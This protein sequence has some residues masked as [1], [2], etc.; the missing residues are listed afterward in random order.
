MRFRKHDGIKRIMLAF[1]WLVLAARAGAVTQ[2]A[3]EAG[4][5]SGDGNSVPNCTFYVPADVARVATGPNAGDIYVAD[6]GNHVIRKISAGGTVSTVAGTFGTAGCLNGVGTSAQFNAPK[7]VAVDAGG[8]TLYVAD[9]N[10][11]TIRRLLLTGPQAGTV[12]VVAGV[13]LTT[14]STNGNTTVARFNL[15][16]DVVLDALGNTLFVADTGN[17]RIRVIYMLNAANYAVGTFAGGSAG[18]ID[19]TT[20]T[21]ARF[22]A[23]AALALEPAG[24]TLYV[25]D[26]NNQ[27]IRRIVTLG[28]HPVTTLAGLAG[29]RGAADGDSLT[30]QF[31]YP[32]GLA[33][34]PGNTSV[35]VSDG[36]NHT[37]RRIDVAAQTTATWLGTAGNT[38]SA[39]GTGTSAQFNHPCG[40]VL[41]GTAAYLYAADV[42]NDCIRRIAVATGAVETWAGG[43]GDGR[44][45]P[46]C[47]FR[48]PMRLCRD[49]AGNAY[50]AD[51]DS[52]VIRRLAS[53]GLVSTLAG[54]AGVAG[55]ADGVGDAARFKFPKGVA[56]SPD[57]QTLYVA[58][59]DNH[60]LRQVALSG[61][62]TGQVSLLAG[63]AGVT[64]TAEGSIGVGGAARFFNPQGLAVSPSG[65]YLYVADT[66]NHSIRRVDL[67]TLN[68]QT[69]FGSLNRV[70]G[71]A[72]GVGTAARFSYPTDLALDAGGN[73]LYV[74]DSGNR[75][76][77]LA[78]LTTGEV[79]TFLG[80]SAGL[81]NPQGVVT[82]DE[83]VFVADA[84]GH[85]LLI[86]DPVR[87]TCHTLAGT[88]EAGFADGGFAAAEFNM[89]L[90]LCYSQD[91]LYVADGFNRRIRRLENLFEIREVELTPV[92]NDIFL[93]GEPEQLV[94]QIAPTI[95]GRDTLQSVTVHNR[96]GTGTAPDD[97]K[98]VRCWFQ[99]GGGTFDALRAVLLGPLTVQSD[100]KTWTSGVFNQVM[101]QTDAIY[102]TL[103]VGDVPTASRTCQFG[104]PAGGLVFASAA[105]PAAELNNTFYQTLAPAGITFAVYHENLLPPTV[106]K[107]QTRV[108]AF[109]FMFTN[110]LRYEFPVTSLTLTVEDRY[111]NTLAPSAVLAGLRAESE[112]GAIYGIW[113]VPAD[114]AGALNLD[115]S[116]ALAV[117]GEKSAGCR[118]FVDVAAQTSADSF[119]LKLASPLAVNRGTVDSMAAADDPTGFPMLTDFAHIENAR[120]NE[121]YANFP[122]P[123]SPPRQA[124]HIKYYLP[125][126]AQVS[127][128]LWT[129][130]EDR[131]L[132]LTDG[133]AQAAGYHSRDWDG[134][135][136]QGQLVG[137]GVYLCRLRLQFNDGTSRLMTRKIAVVR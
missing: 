93:A 66:N 12:D 56:L 43:W 123:F 120:L 25:A 110:A 77:R 106:V 121:S 69:V 124:T 30:A 95:A 127:I 13:T 48:M 44:S 40:L 4:L 52:H 7:G 23:P 102:I 99:A 87:A 29:Q 58:D 132:A 92:L 117:P 105:W 84:A 72:E 128:T 55:S 135:N 62:Q 85:R 96:L 137:S 131:V 22:N 94:L 45:V 122:N 78:D 136:G 21:S 70:S 41:E 63:L 3:T 16:S 57:G 68:C 17:N 74:A 9:A 75:V 36:F 112:D 82:G 100:Q 79:G 80:T 118:I 113:T 130:T 67:V 32:L 81:D 108:E 33:A 119:R 65:Q 134:R 50:L 71:Y 1:G 116:A 103:D 11:H 91:R 5:G 6:T 8:N 109:D 31:N 24:N 46:N 97:I 104:I 73:T 2:V 42:N 35:Y 27:V 51:A 101:H 59:A 90:G 14:G 114:A 37:V 18:Y 125:Q 129:L 64:G 10:N 26:A 19:H 98:A 38:G 53:N 47:A 83:F 88:G 115:F 86:C 39:D 107:G 34:G 133:E 60:L 28:T 76:I 126:P 15:P 49:G 54:R 61:A 20:G 111:G 89:P